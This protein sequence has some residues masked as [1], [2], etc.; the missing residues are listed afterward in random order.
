MLK[1]EKKIDGSCLKLEKVTFD[2][3]TMSSFILS[4][5]CIYGS[6]I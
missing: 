2:H 1:S 6:L 3:Q 5:K 4:M